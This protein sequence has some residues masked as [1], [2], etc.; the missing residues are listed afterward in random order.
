MVQSDASRMSRALLLALAV[1]LFTTPVLT[2]QETK[3]G[4]ARGFVG[5]MAALVYGTAWPTAMYES[6][7]LKRVERLN[8][9]LALLVRLSGESG[10]G[11]NLWLDLVFEFRKGQ[12]YDLRVVRHN[13][14]L[15]P[16]FKT[17]AAIAGLTMDLAREFASSR[18]DTRVPPRGGLAPAPSPP[19]SRT[20]QAVSRCG[21]PIDLWIRYRGLNARWSTLGVWAIAANDTTYLATAGERLRLTSSVIYYYAEI[22][23][24][25]YS[26]SG[27][28]AVLYDDVS[29]PMRTDTLAIDAR[30]SYELLFSCDNLR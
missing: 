24:S 14:V 2:G 22:P 20:L 30:G 21:Q 27:K 18:P 13:A 10:F 23:D 7:Q 25:K 29:F 6:W 12:F 16:P 3:E 9:G 19:A 5:S 15:V 28:R 8:S 26:W 4:E 11:G 1:S 17:S